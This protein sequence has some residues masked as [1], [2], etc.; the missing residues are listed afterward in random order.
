MQ[1]NKIK[2]DGIYIPFSILSKKSLNLIEKIIIADISYFE[3]F[4]EESEFY[5]GT[6]R[7][8]VLLGVNESTVKR[9][10]KHLEDLRVINRY[11][12]IKNN[13]KSRYRYIAI[14]EKVL[15]E[16]P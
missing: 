1:Q 5:M 14:T 4:S 7:I 3:H 9:A 11:Y 8:S 15:N 13:M 16:L 12:H 6:K 10:I 2:S